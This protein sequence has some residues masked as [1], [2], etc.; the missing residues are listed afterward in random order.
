MQPRLLFV[1]NFAEY[2]LSHRLLL[3]QRARATGYDLHVAVP[4]SEPECTRIRA[5]GFT[6]HTIPMTRQ[7]KNPLQ[8]LDTLLSLIRLFRTVRPHIVHNFTIKP[9]I[10]GGI[11][12]RL[13]RIPAAVNSV[14]GLGAVF[15]DQRPH[16]QA[17]RGAVKLA[18]RAAL[19]HPNA[20]LIF[21]NPDDQAV[22]DQGDILPRERSV[23]VPGSGVDLNIFTPQPFPTGDP[24]V[25][26]ASRMMW[27]KGV[28]E[29]VEAARI[30]KS[31]GVRA[32]FQ[33]AGDSDSHHHG[34]VPREQLQA[35]HDEGVIE[36][37][38]FRT[39]MPTVY[40]QAT[41]A[42]LPSYYREGVPKALIE[43]AACGRP[44]V[45]TDTPGCREIVHDGE[46]G[47]LV[48]KQDARAAADAL[49]KLIEARELCI[50]M[51]AKSRE[52][53]AN[54]FGID[55]IAAQIIRV[56][57]ELLTA[58]GIAAPATAQAEVNA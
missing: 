47:Y 38:G 16:M 26:L 43:A 6:L 57:N 54:G 15:V 53:A 11:A 25:V 17:L 58:A 4:P 31:E 34:S 33:L 28:G 55:Q 42:C 5:E 48:P 32:R 18:Y 10:Y 46:N 7:G 44:I 40:A 27:E 36:W 3:A 37:L 45:T 9:V 20:R 50:Q 41:I 1:G 8:E 21:Q 56:Y 30:L 52:I 14:T 19:Q 35:W 23:V 22:F 51:G 2:F 24:V 29:F 49:R 39:D 13:T 12:T